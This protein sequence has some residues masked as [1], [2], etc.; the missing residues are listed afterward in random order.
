MAEP[1]I[2]PAE[3]C[4]F[5]APIGADGSETRHRSDGVRDYIVKPAMQEFGLTVLRADDLK[6]PGQITLR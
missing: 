1:T 4:F 3:E 6:K 5:I 2:D